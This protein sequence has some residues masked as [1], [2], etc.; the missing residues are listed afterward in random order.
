MKDL[1]LS[2]IAIYTLKVF[3][4]IFVVS[5]ILE[6]GYSLVSGNSFDDALLSWQDGMMTR[7]RFIRYFLIALFLGMYRVSKQKKNEG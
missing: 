2:A 6:V 7:N 3:V 1:N 5:F 4:G